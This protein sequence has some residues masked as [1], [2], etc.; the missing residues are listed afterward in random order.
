MI[1]VRVGARS[2]E[3]NSDGTPIIGD[4]KY[5]EGDSRRLGPQY[6]HYQY[7]SRIREVMRRNRRRGGGVK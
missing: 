5:K 3:L 1:T 4:G 7:T 6:V 2:Y